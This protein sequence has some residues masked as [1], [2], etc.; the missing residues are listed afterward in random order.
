MLAR[1]KQPNEVIKKAI[2]SLDE[3]VRTVLESSSAV[4][5]LRGRPKNG[6]ISPLSPFA[7][8]DQGEHSHAPRLRTH[9]GRGAHPHLSQLINNVLFFLFV[10]I[11]RLTIYFINLFF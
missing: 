3:M 1:L 8:P 11:D 9:R 7:G 10:F 6:K 4:K 5:Q 2:L